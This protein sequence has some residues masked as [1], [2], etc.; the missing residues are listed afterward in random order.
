MS[1]DPCLRNPAPGYLGVELHH[2]GAL[3]QPES[4][5]DFLHRGGHGSGGQD[6]KGDTAQG[7]R[8][9]GIMERC[10]TRGGT[11]ERRYAGGA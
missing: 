6:R 10:H 8:Q 1:I 11:V 5:H 3:G 9:G 7:S 4:L 2:R